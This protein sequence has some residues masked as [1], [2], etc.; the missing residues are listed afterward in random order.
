M[1]PGRPESSAMVADWYI[2]AGLVQSLAAPPV[3]VTPK[4]EQKGWTVQQ[5]GP[6]C[7]C[8]GRASWEKCLGWVQLN[9]KFPCFHQVLM[10]ETSDVWGK[11]VWTDCSFTSVERF[12]SAPDTSPGGLWWGL[13]SRSLTLSLILHLHLHLNLLPI[14]LY[15]KQKNRVFPEKKK[16]TYRN[17]NKTE[18]FQKESL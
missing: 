18:P 1:H 11:L 14:Y 8:W 6:I 17:L 15:L 10:I 4:S 16:T 2:W 3:L 7:S 13:L 12:I 5:C 9:K